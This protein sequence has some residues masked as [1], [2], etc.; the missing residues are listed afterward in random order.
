MTKGY[1]PASRNDTAKERRRVCER[2]PA[3]TASHWSRWKLQQKLF[4]RSPRRE[5]GV[6]RVSMTIEQI[7]QARER[8]TPYLR[9]TPLVLSEPLSRATGNRIW[10][11]LESQQPTGAFKVRP[12]LNGM[13]A[14]LDQARESG[15]IASSSGNFAQAV[16]YAARE[17]GVSAQ[18]VMMKKSSPFKI[19]GT[20]RLGGEVVFSENT[21]TDRWDTTFRIQGES[22]RLLLH[23]Y[24]SEATIA[25]DATI[26]LEL[27]GQLD[28]D[29]TVL[30][31]IS[32]GGLISGIA[33]AVKAERPACSVIGIQPAANGS[34]K[35]SIEQGSRGD[36]NARPQHGRR[37]GCA[38]TWRANLCDCS[39]THRRHCARRRG[40]DCKGREDPRR[41]A[42]AGCRTRRSRRGRRAAF[43]QNPDR[44][45]RCRVC[46]QRRQHPPVQTGRIDRNRSVVAPV[47]S[48]RCQLSQRISDGP[49]EAWTEVHG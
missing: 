17:L 11:K 47:Y 44:W 48:N 5:P 12:A 27:T 8:L 4:L 13:L 29:F 49:T 36:G 46:A 2:G 35:K 18:I 30:V 26:G 45:P 14:R 32:G 7:R 25:G 37:A 1:S 33:S 42:E 39:R 15:V 19:E 43:R 24:D 6:T 9:P 20:R 40:G 16:A 41:G 10:L 38:N 22:G 23:P 28:S 21:F 3:A 31:P 34:M